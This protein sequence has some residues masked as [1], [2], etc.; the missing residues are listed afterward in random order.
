[1]ENK[2]WLSIVPS[3]LK[4]I[5]TFFCYGQNAPVLFVEGPSD[6]K[7]YEQVVNLFTGDN[8]PIF[9]AGFNEL[10]RKYI[11]QFGSPYFDPEF[12]NTKKKNMLENINNNIKRL[13]MSADSNCKFVEEVGKI[14]KRSSREIQTNKKLISLNHINGFGIV[15]RDFYQDQTVKG[16]QYD[17]NNLAYTVA[18][19]YETSI[20]YLFFPLICDAKLKEDESFIYKLSALLEFVGTQG[21]LQ[22]CSLN[23]CNYS[24]HL[25]ECLKCITNY[26]FMPENKNETDKRKLILHDKEYNPA[27]GYFVE[28]VNRQYFDFDGYLN[29]QIDNSKKPFQSL[30]DGNKPYSIDDQ[31]DISNYKDFCNYFELERKSIFKNFDFYDQTKQWLNNNDKNNMLKL[32]QYANGHIL[33]EH[34]IKVFG[35]NQPYRF[36]TDKELTDYF[37]NY[38]KTHK[39]KLLE[40]SPLKQYLEYRQSV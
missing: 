17:K 37:I 1:M 35:G 32:F 20:F 5:D 21:I 33:W 23:S 31:R 6:K 39:D 30:P 9:V 14:C 16:L 22:K 7:Y 15:D 13:D 26:V 38:I 27:K 8:C 29:A 3:Y 25:T 19:D 40:Y 28:Y 2:T 18:H 24:K 34:F 36:D 12:S 10:E 4:L 11:Q